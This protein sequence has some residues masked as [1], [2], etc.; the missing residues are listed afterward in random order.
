MDSEKGPKVAADLEMWDFTSSMISW[1]V[2]FIVSIAKFVK[3]DVT[4]WDDQVRLFA[5]ATSFTGKVD[6]VIANAGICPKDEV[7]T[8]AGTFLPFAPNPHRH[9]L[10]SNFANR[11][12]RRSYRTK[13]QSYRCQIKRYTLH[14]QTCTSLLCKTKWGSTITRARRYLFG[15]YWVWSCFSG[16]PEG[17]GVS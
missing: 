3:C 2:M 12:R 8:F 7:F 16:L 10:N 13:P 15:A 5:E 9:H 6:Y 17:T 11:Q 14:D 1:H 4:I